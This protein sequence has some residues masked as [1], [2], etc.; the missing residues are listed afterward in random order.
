M[1][2]ELIFFPAAQNNSILCNSFNKFSL[3]P[4]D[5]PTIKLISVGAN[6]I[7]FSLKKLEANFKSV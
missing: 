7:F 5:L 4:A 1:S 2:F 6:E 3:S